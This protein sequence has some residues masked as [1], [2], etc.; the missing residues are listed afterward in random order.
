MKQE[1]ISGL[2]SEQEKNAIAVLMAGGFVALTECKIEDTRELSTGRRRRTFRN[3]GRRWDLMIGFRKLSGRDLGKQGQP[4]TDS[5]REPAMEAL[6][7]D[8]G[9]IKVGEPEDFVPGVNDNTE[10]DGIQVGPAPVETMTKSQLLAE[11][12][13]YPQLTGEHKLK[14]D[15]LR[16]AV[17]E[18]REIRRQI[19]HRTFSLTE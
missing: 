19:I 1:E 9:L 4:A 11:A 3:S 5:W 13:H 8:F 12:R 2:L 10:A 14:V 18:Q 16:A 6:T 7:I 17:S 15:E